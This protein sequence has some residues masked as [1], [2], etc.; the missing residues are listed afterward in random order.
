MNCTSLKMLTPYATHHL[1]L[2]GLEQIRKDGNRQGRDLRHLR[3]PEEDALN[4]NKTMVSAGC[5]IEC[6][7]DFCIYFI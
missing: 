3:G 1:P 2:V 4:E 5:I 7:F 6:L